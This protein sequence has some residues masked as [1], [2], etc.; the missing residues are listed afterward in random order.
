MEVR[1]EVRAPTGDEAAVNARLD[2]L[3]DSV[4]AGDAEANASFYHEN[5][6]LAFGQMSPTGERTS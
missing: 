4:R 2:A 5:G 1:H 6:V 3:I